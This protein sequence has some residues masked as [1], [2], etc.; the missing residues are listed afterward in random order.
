[1][2]RSRLGQCAGK[3]L[4]S[5]EDMQVECSSQQTRTKSW[6]LRCRSGEAVTAEVP[7]IAFP[8]HPVGWGMHD[9]PVPELCSSPWADILLFLKL[10]SLLCLF[11]MPF[12]QCLFSTKETQTKLQDIKGDSRT[13]INILFC[14]GGRA[15]IVLPGSRT[16]LS[17][18]TRKVLGKNVF[19]RGQVCVNEEIRISFL[20]TPNSNIEWIKLVNGV[21]LPNSD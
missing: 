16:L 19:G 15:N 12:I 20:I 14:S 8:L 4:V 5:R 11:L 10:S 3:P 17:I 2:S 13:I 21:P 7:F 1:M 9:W 6:L 18:E